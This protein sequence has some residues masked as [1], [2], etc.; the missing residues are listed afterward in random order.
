MVRCMYDRR[1]IYDIKTVPDEME[2]GE[3]CDKYSLVKHKSEL[4]AVNE[5]WSMGR[6][7]SENGKRRRY[8]LIYRSHWYMALYYVKAQSMP[9]AT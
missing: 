9:L 8:L 2:N 3:S 4:D 6:T 7:F 5:Q 1:N